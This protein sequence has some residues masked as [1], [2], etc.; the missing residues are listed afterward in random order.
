MP[1]TCDTSKDL[2]TVQTPARWPYQIVLPLKR[3]IDGLPL[4]QI[5]CIIKDEGPKVLLTNMF[6]LPTNAE[7]LMEIPVEEYNS[8]EAMIDDGWRV[9]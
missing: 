5:G 2:E 3:N 1:R 8:F 4:T 6:A 9:D 7:A